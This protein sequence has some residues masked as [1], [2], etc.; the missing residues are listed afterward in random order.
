MTKP[1]NQDRDREPD[2]RKVALQAVAYE[3]D[4]WICASS[5]VVE[6]IIQALCVTWQAGQEALADRYAEGVEA[7]RREARAEFFED[8][9]LISGTITVETP[10]G[11]N[12]THKKWA[13]NIMG[14]QCRHNIYVRNCEECLADALMFIDVQ[15]RMMGREEWSRS[16][17]TKRGVDDAGQG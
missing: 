12:E 9:P 11:T 16:R 17:Q 1:T 15:S 7:G 8:H 14:H 4:D 10:I 5:D 3:G 6:H 2:F 13:R